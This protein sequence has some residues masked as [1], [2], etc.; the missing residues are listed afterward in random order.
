VVK[1]FLSQAGVPFVVKDVATDVV[2]R[3]E[4]LRAGFLLPPVTVIGG[5]AV[6]GYQPDRIEELL[7]AVEMEQDS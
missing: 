5:V 3:E 4:F 7:S 6:E 1:E 2:A